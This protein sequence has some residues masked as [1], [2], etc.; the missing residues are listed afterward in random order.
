MTE[1]NR[2]K[3]SKITNRQAI[4]KFIDEAGKAGKEPLDEFGQ[5]MRLF[6]ALYEKI[7]NPATR[8]EGALEK[9]QLVYRLVLEKLGASGTADLI[10]RD[11]NLEL[12]I[13]TDPITRSE[14][15]NT[16]LTFGNPANGANVVLMVHHDTVAINRY[17][18]ATQEGVLGGRAVQDDTIHLA[19]TINL[20][21][22]INTPAKGAI[23]IV[24]TDYEENGCRGSSAI[25]EKLLKRF[26][27]KYPLVFLALEST[28]RALAI[29]HKGKFSSEIYG[30][31]GSGQE[32]KA[33]LNFC[34]QLFFV[35][36]KA[37]KESGEDPD[38]KTVGT[39]TCGR[40][41]DCGLWAK[42][43]F[44]TG[45][46]I[47]PEK[48]E[49]Y[50]K[51]SGDSFEEEDFFNHAKNYL[52]NPLFKLKR[53]ENEITVISRSKKLHPAAFCFAQDETVMPL[54]Y[55]LLKTLAEK[56]PE[57][58]IKEVS[59]GKTEKQNSNPVIAKIIFKREAP[60]LKKL[61]QSARELVFSKMD[62]CGSQFFRLEKINMVDL[63]LSPRDKLTEDLRKILSKKGGQE[64]ETITAHFMTDIARIFNAAKKKW[65]K[66]GN[67][68]AVYGF[69]FGVGEPEK[70]H[71]KEEVSTEDVFFLIKTLRVFFNWLQ[72]RLGAKN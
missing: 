46:K 56:Y 23:T 15:Y 53:K 72:E 64:V 52:T 70:T 21:P 22:K 57:K 61:K 40:A 69:V 5:T 14:T 47:T 4:E 66:M 71:G 13:A 55:L 32:G 8:P 3:V 6:L 49:N 16:I 31:T 9:A 27:Q 20:L 58:E 12:V 28:A 51:K 34:R 44:R 43:D 45:E 11:I 18:L 63:V 50:W 17:R 62:I 42:L 35:Q 19:A 24:F 7:N 36:Q 39:S 60:E 59:W 37:E 54:L 10:S 33:T 65:G 38:Q 68:S 2:P 29:G 30:K 67:A 41:D 48:V 25:K 26:S 1:P